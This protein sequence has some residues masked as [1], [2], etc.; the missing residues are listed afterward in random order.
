MA[1]S[2]LINISMRKVTTENMIFHNLYM[3]KY[4]LTKKKKKKKNHVYKRN[5]VPQKIETFE[6][7]KICTRQKSLTKQFAKICIHKITKK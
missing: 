7:A 6:F 1:N 5:Y 4:V 2:Q 3:S